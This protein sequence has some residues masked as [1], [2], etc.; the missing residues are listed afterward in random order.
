MGTNG[1][2]GLGR[3]DVQRL[4]KHPR[5]E[6]TGWGEYLAVHV[7][8]GRF[9]QSYLD[10][11]GPGE[12]YLR[13]PEVCAPEHG[14]YEAQ[15]LGPRYLLAPHHVERAILQAGSGREPETCLVALEAPQEPSN[16]PQVPSDP[17]QSLGRC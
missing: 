2:R 6:V 15:Y 11:G 9:R 3:Q 16:R 12:V 7:R 8:R 17:P 1:I 14:R 13:V 10:L 5:L 4:R